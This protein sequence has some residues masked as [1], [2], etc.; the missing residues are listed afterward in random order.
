MNGIHVYIKVI[1]PFS[2]VHI[3]LIDIAYLGYYTYIVIQ[4][5]HRPGVVMEFQYIV[6]ENDFRIAIC[7]YL[8]FVFAKKIISRTIKGPEKISYLSTGGS[9]FSHNIYRQ[10]KKILI[11]FQN[12]NFNNICTNLEAYEPPEWTNTLQ[13]PW[14]PGNVVEYFPPKVADSIDRSVATG[15][16]GENSLCCT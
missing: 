9:Y 5:D 13:V 16:S 14:R 8:I 2:Y 11:S 3:R 12:C 4:G 1:W 10:K 15:Q 7:W 6:R